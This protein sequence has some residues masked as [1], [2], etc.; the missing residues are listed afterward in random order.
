MHRRIQIYWQ[1]VYVCISYK[2]K[3]VN[4]FTS[5]SPVYTQVFE[6]EILRNVHDIEY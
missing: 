1:F 2:L 4:Y 3:Y 5:F 6:N